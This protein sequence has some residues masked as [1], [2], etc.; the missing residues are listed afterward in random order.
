MY[1]TDFAN[2][3]VS[4]STGAGPGTGSLRSN[5][6]SV[7]SRNIFGPALVHAQH[8]RKTCTVGC[9]VILSVA[10]NKRCVFACDTVGTV[11][12]CLITFSTS[13]KLA[14]TV[15]RFTITVYIEFL[16]GLVKS[17]PNY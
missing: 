3:S 16:M 11:T 9:S 17:G 13:K 7:W 1:S 15:Q 6:T 14:N 2:A 8:L 12:A 5:I 4:D 10:S